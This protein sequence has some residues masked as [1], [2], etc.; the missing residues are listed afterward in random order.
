MAKL[1]REGALHFFDVDFLS[2]DIFWA[3]DRN[4][5]TRKGAKAGY[6][7][8]L[9]YRR[10]EVNSEVYLVHR[11]I[12]MMF[13]GDWPKHDI[14]H[15]DG[16]PINNALLNLRDVSASKNLMNQRKSQRGSAVPYL[17]VSI[18]RNKYQALICVN[19]KNKSLGVY[20]TPE[21]AYEAYKAAKRELH[22]I[23]L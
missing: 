15:I 5:R 3:V 19:G 8:K 2:G 12:W 14:D 23:D 1:T 4:N 18:K 10:V 9:G 21:L 7:D 20:E 22:G 17:G 11:L 6:L 13:H 16:N